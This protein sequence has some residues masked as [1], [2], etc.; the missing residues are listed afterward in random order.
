MTETS[1]QTVVEGAQGSER[2]GRRQYVLPSLPGQPAGR[3]GQPTLS[4]PAVNNNTATIMGIKGRIKC[5]QVAAFTNMAEYS[6]TCITDSL[7]NWLVR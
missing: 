6:Q 3:V 4:R 7:L 1:V 5:I 2:M